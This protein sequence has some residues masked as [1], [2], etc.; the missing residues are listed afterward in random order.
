MAH[1]DST[2]RARSSS[3]AAPT[4][5]LFCRTPTGTPVARPALVVG[6]LLATLACSFRDYEYGLNATTTGGASSQVMATGGTSNRTAAGTGG[7]SSQPTL[8]GG[9]SSQPTMTGGGSS[10]LRC[11]DDSGVPCEPACANVVSEDA[12]YPASLI[13]H[14]T[15]DSTS[16][17]D[18]SVPL[19]LNDEINSYALTFHAENSDAIAPKLD[20]KV[21]INGHGN[22]IHLDGHDYYVADGATQVPS[23][24][25][26]GTIAALISISHDTLPVTDAGATTIWPIIS[27]IV[28]QDKDNCG[29][30]QLDLRLDTEQRPEV[31]F[32]YA[33]TSPT[34]SSGCQ[35][36]TFEL[37]LK[38][39]SWAWNTGHWHHV[40]ATYTPQGANQAYVALYWDSDSPGAQQASNDNWHDGQMP[41]SASKLY[42]GTN[43]N[44]ANDPTTQKFQGNIDEIAIFNRPLAAIELAQF[45]LNATTYAGPS[46]CRWQATESHQDGVDAG[47]STA[48]WIAHDTNQ[49]TVKVHDEDWGSGAVAARLA[50][51][52]AAK[53]LTPYREIVLTADGMSVAD[54]PNGSFE[55][56]LSAGDSSCTWYVAANGTSTYQIDLA[57][58]GYCQSASCQFAI[59]NVEWAAI[60]SIWEYPPSFDTKATNQLVY[61]IRRLDL[62]KGSTPIDPTRYGGVFGPNNWCWR[63]QAFQATFGAEA[64]FDADAGSK[65]AGSNSATLYAVL[66]GQDSSGS[67]MVADFGD[68]TLDLSKCDGVVLDATLDPSEAMSNL[69]AYPALNLQDRS[70]SW[71]QWNWDSTTSNGNTVSISAHP[72]VKPVASSDE[73]DPEPYKT[74]WPW[75]PYLYF[76]PFDRSKIA[77]LAIQKNWQWNGS[78]ALRVNAINFVDQQGT[79]YCEMVNHH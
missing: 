15:F 9:T 67:A 71:A 28:M 69:P 14:W 64:R 1:R 51:P 41:G 17:P 8:T 20:A 70:G 56:A 31:A 26:G 40:A 54:T 60:R 44:D 25:S 21:R 72:Y 52:G 77:V 27:T 58:P 43:A 5:F 42:V 78:A 10:S 3:G 37:P 33:Y 6:V 12:G 24:Q 47:V 29:G 39:P 23:L 49:L 18:G 62:V 38:R 59:E 19:G 73:K 32:S 50:A 36:A 55:F 65:D 48:T 68:D 11:P 46:G 16:F 74:I 22:S 2:T 4:A 53:D 63:T 13:A 61:A 7:T 45:S 66:S 76:P 35:T 30:Y 79:R 34:A 75:R 57:N